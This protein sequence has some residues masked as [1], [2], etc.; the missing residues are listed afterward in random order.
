MTFAIRIRPFV[1]A[2]ALCAAACVC[3]LAAQTPAPATVPPA[4]RERGRALSQQDQM[5][6]RTGGDR[7]AF[8]RVLIAFAEEAERA[9]A[10]SLLRAG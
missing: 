5:L 4:L 8:G 10:D 7:V 3:D 6:D 2:A 9:G 1:F